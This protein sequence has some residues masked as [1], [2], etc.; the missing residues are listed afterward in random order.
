M[1]RIYK[2]TPSISDGSC[3]RSSAFTYILMAIVFLKG[4][5]C[6]DAAPEDV[7]VAVWKGE[8]DGI[9]KGIRAPRL[10]NIARLGSLCL[11]TR[12]RK[13]RAP[14][15]LYPGNSR[16]DEDTLSGNWLGVE[17]RTFEHDL[18]VISG[19]EIRLDRSGRDVRGRMHGAATLL[20]V[21]H[22]LV[23][24]E[25]ELGQY[26]HSAHCMRCW[27]APRCSMLLGWIWW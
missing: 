9:L 10:L 27:L 26:Q 23:V 19:V 24:S 6:S 5:D 8:N 25:G 18:L 12:I 22:R 15:A 1:N 20:A 13:P 2:M 16:D 3:L 7:T 14:L 4:P 21:K 11:Y 17:V